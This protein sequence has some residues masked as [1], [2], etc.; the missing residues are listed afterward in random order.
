MSPLRGIWNNVVKYIYTYKV[1]RRS[2]FAPQPPTSNRQG[3]NWAGRQ[4]SI[5]WAKHPNHFRSEQK[6]RYPYIRKPPSPGAQCKIEFTYADWNVGLKL[7]RAPG[8]SFALF[9]W[10]GRAPNG[11]KWTILGQSDQKYI[12]LA[13]FGRFWA[14]IPSF[15]GREATFL[16]LHIRK[17]PR[18]LV[19]IVFWSV[20][21]SSGPKR[22]Y[23]AK[24]DQKCQ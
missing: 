15:V 16:Y 19:H 4:E 13:K 20:M 21:A 23:L 9:F 18:H 6:F 17:P 3:T 5:F 22:Q 8:T 14:K 2:I 10:S 1:G 11:P 12:F 7:H 24:N